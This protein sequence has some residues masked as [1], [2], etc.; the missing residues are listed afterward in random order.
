MSLW[1]TCHIVNCLFV[2]L[3]AYSQ[4]VQF[5][6]WF[7]WT[8]TRIPSWNGPVQGGV[9]HLEK[10]Q[11]HL[12]L[13]KMKTHLCFVSSL[14]QVDSAF[15]FGVYIHITMTQHALNLV[16]VLSVLCDES[17]P[18]RQ[19]WMKLSHFVLAFLQS[20]KTTGGQGFW[21]L[22]FCCQATWLIWLRSLLLDQ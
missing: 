11:L 3:L 20:A 16:V 21:L 15:P 19:F 9:C 13:I 2:I 12:N 6:H 10:M 22:M 5:V 17:I 1:S 14:C 18:F 8:H 4:C 7:Q